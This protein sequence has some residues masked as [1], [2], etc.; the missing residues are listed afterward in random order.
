MLSVLAFGFCIWLWGEYLDRYQHSP[1]QIRAAMFSML[2]V[3]VTAELLISHS[4]MRRWVV[5]VVLFTNVWGGLDALL[6]YPS[7][8]DLDSFFSVKQLGLLLAKSF[9]YAIGI[10]H[11]KL[12]VAVSLIVLLL[13]SWGLVVVYLM[14]L[15]PDAAAGGCADDDADLLVR[16]WRLAVSSDERR[17]CLAGCAKWWRRK[18]AAAADIS[19]LACFAICLASPDFRRVYKRRCRRV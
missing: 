5:G 8:Y 12:H 6:R 17:Q 11:F 3:A 1:G 2:A 4:I 14:A 16:L 9:S 7:V 19:Q 15:P 13:I 10:I 18:L